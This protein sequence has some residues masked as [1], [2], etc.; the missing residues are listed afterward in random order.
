[1]GFRSS[2]FES[3]LGGAS[4]RAAQLLQQQAAA[5]QAAA[6]QAAQAQAQAQ[7]GAGMSLEHLAAMQAAQQMGYS[8]GAPWPLGWAA[9]GGAGAAARAACPGRLPSFLAGSAPAS[10]LALA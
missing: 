9:C 2:S 7:Q 1:M 8:T 4:P 6:Q 3:G 5:Q 10:A